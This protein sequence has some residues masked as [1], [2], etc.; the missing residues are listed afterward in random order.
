MTTDA[1][2]VRYVSSYTHVPVIDYDRP[3]GGLLVGS[4][5]GLM[6]ATMDSSPAFRWCVDLDVLPPAARWEDWL[7]LVRAFVQPMA[8]VGWFS[9]T[10]PQR[11]AAVVRRLRPAPMLYAAGILPPDPF[12]AHECRCHTLDEFLRWAS[13]PELAT[14]GNRLEEFA[15]VTHAQAHGSFEPRACVRAHA[16]VERDGADDDPSR[17]SRDVIAGQQSV[18]L[19]DTGRPGGCVNEYRTPVWSRPG[20]VLDV[21]DPTHEQRRPRLADG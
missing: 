18:K 17:Q 12:A 21:F 11:L 9:I 13:Q 10:R 5:G 4:G 7:L 15:G 16:I 14:M 8:I 6:M 3:S 2:M 20:P 1:E 19:G